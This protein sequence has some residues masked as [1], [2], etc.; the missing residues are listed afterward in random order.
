[1]TDDAR[2]A[3][4]RPRLFI[5]YSHQDTA[6]KDRVLKHVRVAFRDGE[7]E[8]RVDLWDD[9]RIAVGDAWFAEIEQALA[10]ADAAI[11]LVSVDFLDSD[12]IRRIEIPRLL[13]RRAQAGVRLIPLL[14]RE[15]AWKQQ[16]WLADLQM[17]PSKAKPLQTADDVDSEL[18]RFAEEVAR[19]VR[20][21]RKAS[22]PSAVPRS[23][24]RL[25]PA[26]ETAYARRDSLRDAGADTTEIDTQ[27]L[28]LKREMRTGPQLPAGYPLADGRYQLVR[29]LGRGGF[30][31]V[32]LAIDRQ[33][34]DDVAIKVLHGQYSSSEER[35]DRLFRGAEQMEKLDHPHIVKVVAAPMVEG[36][37]AFYAMEYLA[38]GDFRRAVLDGRL[39]LNQRLDALARIA[40]ALDYAHARGVIHRDVKPANILLAADG[41]PKLA[42][43]DL[44]RANDTTG[45]TRTRAGMGSFTYAAPESLMDAAAVTAACDVY[46]LAATWVFALQG[47]ALDPRFVHDRAAFLQHLDVSDA[48][49]EVLR[50]AL[51]VDPARRPSS[52]TELTRSLRKAMRV[53]PPVAVPPAPTRAPI[54]P[55][56]APERKRPVPAARRVA[57]PPAP[58]KPQV[59]VVRR[60]PLGWKRAAV[61][62]AVVGLVVLAAVYVPSRID[63]PSAERPLL[64]PTPSDQDQPSAETS[65]APAV[66]EPDQASINE[67]PIV[68]E[69][70][71]EAPSSA[72]EPP[73]SHMPEMIQLPVGSFLMGDADSAYADERPVRRVE[74]QAFEISRTEVTVAQYR[75]CVEAGGCDEPTS[76]LSS[77]NWPIEDRANHP[78]NCMSWYEAQRYA[79]WAGMRLPSEAEWEYAARSAGLD[80]AYPWGDEAAT[81]QRAVLSE[82]QLGTGCDGMAHTQAVCSKPLGNTEQGLCDM[83]GNVREWVEDD[84]H[85]NYSGAPTD[86]SAWIDTPRASFRVLRG[87]SWRLIPRFARVAYRYRGAP[88]YRNDFLGFRVARSLPSSL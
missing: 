17:R 12:F 7:S 49:R 32:W 77:C 20:G 60:T 65:E 69:K 52:T 30:A 76:E 1:M 62:M 6:W 64:R 43:F 2:A 35:R 72:T 39:D 5:S 78:M 9:Q 40:E 21:G 87:G 56:P 45:M 18:A 29:Q 50:Q 63:L 57:K 61:W 38:G 55:P 82:Q 88:S 67:E 79:A 24:R 86:G 74:I 28:T 84:W 44:V 48:V 70:S 4:D 23:Y 14:L 68:T 51:N 46:A 47:K 58:R 71:I 81:C 16:P 59:A 10:R 66:I 85:G 22:S 34:P 8:P 37:W 11:L 53:Q 19:L 15:C 83:A 80:R 27:I 36:G 31:T 3:D 13:K 75:A 33:R 42:D 41:T 73:V 25:S 26:L 54:V